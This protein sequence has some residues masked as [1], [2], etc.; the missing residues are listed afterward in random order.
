LAVKQL[1]QDNY[2]SMSKAIGD[3]GWRMLRTMI[4]YKCKDHG[5]NLLIIGRFEP[6]SKTCSVCGNIYQEL[7]RDEKEW[8]CKKCN[9]HHDRDIN[10]AKNIKQ[11][12]LIKSLG[13]DFGERKRA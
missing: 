3:T 10:A 7:K 6:S 11:F 12:A 5:K 9:I 2:T 1:E 4:E 13:K 8:A